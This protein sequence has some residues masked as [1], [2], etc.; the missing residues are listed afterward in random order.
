M[1]VKI[2][3]TIL[4]ETGELFR[5]A[6]NAG[7]AVELDNFVQQ[8]KP[9]YKGEAVGLFTIDSG[10]ASDSAAEAN[11]DSNMS[12]RQLSEALEKTAGL[13][14]A[15]GSASKAKDLALVSGQLQ[16]HGSTPVN[17]L[18]EGVQDRQREALRL[19]VA[20]LSRQL[21]ANEQ[22]ERAF[23]AL[24]AALKKLDAEAVSAVAV[25]YAQGKTRYASKPK[26]LAAIADKRFERVR[27]A[28]RMQQS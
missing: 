23:G 6:G 20:D 15:A 3:A 22:D 14:K 9:F 10:A 21:V 5:L 26:A 1:K 28:S 12:A 7:F 4:K 27:L 24:L 8:L 13:V 2:F 18:I 19:R 16:S 11:R 17:Q 25:A